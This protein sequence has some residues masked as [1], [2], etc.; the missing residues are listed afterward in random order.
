MFHVIAYKRNICSISYTACHN[1]EKR[2]VKQTSFAMEKL[3][4]KED[5]PSV[6]FVQWIR[7]IQIQSDFE[8]KIYAYA[9]NICMRLA[10]APLHYCKG[11]NK[12]SIQ[13]QNNCIHS[14]AF[15]IHSHGFN[16]QR[17]KLLFWRKS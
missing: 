1:Y 13:I 17:G 4:K 7:M 15:N 6:S 2:D 8:L 16:V 5:S 3:Q 10:F 14:H 9:N 12:R 11:C